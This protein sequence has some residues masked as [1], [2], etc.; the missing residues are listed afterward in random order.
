MEKSFVSAFSSLRSSFSEEA[1]MSP[2]MSRGAT[3]RQGAA[4][5][6]AAVL[7]CLA[8]FFCLYDANFAAALSLR[9]SN[10]AKSL[11]APTRAPVTPLENGEVVEMSAAS[12]RNVRAWCRM[13]Q[14][15]W[16]AFNRMCLDQ[17]LGDFYRRAAASGPDALFDYKEYGN[18]TVGEEGRSLPGTEASVKYV[19]DPNSRTHAGRYI[20]GTICTGSLNY[21]CKKILEA[22]VSTPETD[23]AAVPGPEEVDRILERFDQ[24]TPA[25]AEA[26]AEAAELM[27]PVE[28]GEY[29]KE[30]PVEEALEN[31]SG[32][33]A[34]LEAETFGEMPVVSPSGVE[35]PEL[36][37]EETPREG[38][39]AASIPPG[40]EVATG[41]EGGAG[42][43]IPVEEETGAEGDAGTTSPAE[44]ALPGGAA[45]EEAPSTAPSEEMVGGLTSAEE[46]AGGNDEADASP[47]TPTTGATPTTT[48]TP[49]DEEKAGSAGGGVGEDASASAT[50]AAAAE[51]EGAGSATPAEE[52]SGSADD[53]STTTA[54]TTTT[55]STSGEEGAGG[56]STTTAAAAAG[57]TPAEDAGGATAEGEDEKAT[58][59]DETTGG[60]AVRGADAD[61]QETLGL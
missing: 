11:D 39:G 30:L 18:L 44:E 45:L 27:L 40:E 22:G 47:T 60:V 21:A 9:V 2:R 61:A 19:A 52:A 24:Q 59:P 34:A 14:A 13:Y 1:A 58:L 42:A 4:V 17:E 41:F 12:F 50:P 8:D 38:E 56:A 37:P 55:I 23:P 15:Q 48:M 31:L 29:E 35:T 43:S 10:E 25:E 28:T 5:S 53:A 51:E 36:L 6:L 49:A 54:A 46:G 20:Y 57:T 26:R 32:F 33:H 3:W 16:Q 7:V